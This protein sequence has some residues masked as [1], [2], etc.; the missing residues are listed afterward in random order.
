MP[1]D[2]FR[3]PPATDKIIWGHHPDGYGLKTP[4]CGP[5]DGYV[6]FAIWGPSSHDPNDIEVYFH[7]KTRLVVEIRPRQG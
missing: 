3:H 1:G 5:H 4:L 7:D 2:W 6:Q